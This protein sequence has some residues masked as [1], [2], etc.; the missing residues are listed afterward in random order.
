[1]I[2]DCLHVLIPAWELFKFAKRKELKINEICYKE[3]IFL[4]II[5]VSMGTLVGRL[6]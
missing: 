1:M 6:L 2:P 3:E 5:F 4:C